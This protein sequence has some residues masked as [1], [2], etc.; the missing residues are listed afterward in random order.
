MNDVVLN[1]QIIE[2]ELDWKIV[3]RLDTAYLCGS[4]NDDRR[5]LLREEILHGAFVGQVKLRAVALRQI[6]ET[7]MFESADQSAAHQTAVTSHE[8][9]I[10]FIHELTVAPEHQPRRFSIF[11]FQPLR[12]PHFIG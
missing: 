6:M 10:R 11:F 7:P 8:D 5:F 3:I 1:P 12:N 2:Q 4:K 9:L